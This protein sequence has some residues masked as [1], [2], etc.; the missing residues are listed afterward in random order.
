MENVYFDERIYRYPDLENPAHWS[1]PNPCGTVGMI[2]PSGLQIGLVMVRGVHKPRFS[3]FVP[4]FLTIFHMWSAPKDLLMV[5]KSSN[6]FKNW[7]KLKKNLVKLR[8][9]SIS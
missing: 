1:V 3:S 2:P 9:K 6:L 5:E 7:D 8:L 4:N